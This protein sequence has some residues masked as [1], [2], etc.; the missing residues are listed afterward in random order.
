MTAATAA[1]TARRVAGFAGQ[2]RHG[3]QRELREALAAGAPSPRVL[4][5]G[6]G[7]GGIGMAVRLRRAGLETFTIVDKADGVGGVWRNNTYPGAACDVPSHLYS[8]SFAP[9]PSWSTRFAPQAEILAYLERC[10][11]DFGLRPHLRLG[12]EVSAAEWDDDASVWRVQTAD[13]EELEADVVITGL[14]QLNRPSIP[15]LDGLDEFTGP[16]F[17]S[18]RWR[19]DVDLVGRRVA[20]VGSGASALQF[21]PLV[22]D[23]ASHVD[24]YQR[25]P[26]YVIPKRDHA[27]TPARQQRY[28]RSPLGTRPPRWRTYWS[29]EARFLTFRQGSWMG[30]LLE[31]AVARGLE[32]MVGPELPRPAL[33]PD[34][35]V[36]CKRILQS[37][38][39]Y[40]TL[41]RSDVDVVTNPIV[42]IEPDGVRTADGARRPCEVLVFATGFAATEFLAP[43]QITGRQGVTLDDHWASGA[44]AYLGV[45]TASL[46]NLFLLYGP[47]TNLGH[48]SIVFMLEAQAHYIIEVLADLVL[49]GR[50]T[51]EVDP[52]VEA[53]F[54]DRLQR[55]AQR[56]VWAADCESWYKDAN[57]RITN[58]WPRPTLDY[59]WR[60]RSVRPGDF[61]YDGVAD[62]PADPAEPWRRS[63]SPSR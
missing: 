59:W 44:E 16:T 25:S 56:T 45:A 34:Y 53:R 40:S 10:V 1:E 60:T 28:A 20:V 41:Q 33:V 14:G 36:G 62:P 22:A 29:F 42:G 15:D 9:N 4:V 31:K 19:H 61:R 52:Q 51:A 2:A 48:N 6:A 18:A 17:H 26:N 43:L 39:W 54:N 30:A 38:D 24:L 57:G 37:N 7:F 8:F 27:Y 23:Q 58:N 21:L 46:P 35:P 63:A 5:I 13:G 49:G 3:R 12:V 47:N 11:D 50:R 32:P 55:D